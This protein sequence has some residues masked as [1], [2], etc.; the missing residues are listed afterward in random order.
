[1]QGPGTDESTSDV[2]EAHE[3]APDTV[4]N[5]G[6]GN[7]ELAAT[8]IDPSIPRG[9]GAVRSA[10]AV[11]S[12][13]GGYRIERVLGRG[14]MGTVFLAHDERLGRAVALKTMN[15]ELAA[16]PAAKGRFLREARAAAQVEHDNVIPIWQVGEEAGVPFIAMPLLQGESLAAR[17]RQRLAGG[18][19]AVRRPGRAVSPLPHPRL[20]AVPAATG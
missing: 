4:V 11:P 6:Q 10:A 3:A 18:R 19:S 16:D 13:L 12:C 17:L 7:A 15:P 14:G 9:D 5:P 2:R 8:V 1:M 20:R